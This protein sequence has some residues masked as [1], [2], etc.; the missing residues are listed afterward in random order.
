M[1]SSQ[2]N[3][4]LFSDLPFFLFVIILSVNLTGAAHSSLYAEPGQDEHLQDNPEDYYAY[5]NKC[6]AHKIT[7]LSIIAE[8]CSLGL[9]PSMDSLISPLSKR[10]SMGMLLTEYSRA[11]AGFSST[12]TLTILTF[13]L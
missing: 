3:Q 10:I 4:T 12:F 11:V 7:F 2:G 9:D 8:S 13:P 5:E 1:P 6:F